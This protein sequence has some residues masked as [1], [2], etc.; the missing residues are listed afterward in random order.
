MGLYWCSYIYVGNRRVTLKRA[1]LLPITRL[2]RDAPT[3]VRQMVKLTNDS[4]GNEI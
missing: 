1:T 3:A 2:S 4:K